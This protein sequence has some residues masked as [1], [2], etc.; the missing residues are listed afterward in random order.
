MSRR[1]RMVA[2]G[3]SSLDGTPSARAA[4]VKRNLGETLV[5]GA[6]SEYVFSS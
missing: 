5:P 3:S 4:S 6:L 2:M 1:Y